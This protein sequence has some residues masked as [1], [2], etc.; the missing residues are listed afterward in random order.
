MHFTK[1]RGVRARDLN[2]VGLTEFQLTQSEDGRQVWTYKNVKS[3]AKWEIIKSLD[4]GMQQSTIAES[5]G[6]DKGYVSRVKKQAVKDGILSKKCK[7]T[8][9]GFSQLSS[10][11]E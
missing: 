1:T 3:A 7:L 6:I 10:Q 8:Q 5:V 4:E 11:P 2:L 9:A